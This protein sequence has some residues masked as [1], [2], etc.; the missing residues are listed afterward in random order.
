MFAQ[1]TRILAIA[2][3]TAFILGHAQ[4]AEQGEGEEVNLVGRQSASV[5][6]L[7]QEEQIPHAVVK[8]ADVAGLAGLPP[9]TDYYTIDPEVVAAAYSYFFHVEGDGHVFVVGSFI[10][11]AK[12]C[13]ELAVLEDIKKRN[14]GKEFASGLG[15][16]LKGIGTGLGNLVMHPGLSMKNAGEHF[17][18]TGRALERAVDSD[19]KVGR[20]ATGTDR[21]HLGGGPAGADRRRLAYELGVDVYTSNPVLQEAL[22]EY[23]R[24]RAAGGF[25]TWAIPY[26]IGMLSVMNPVGDD[27]NTE[28]L[29]RD[30]E[31]NELRRKIGEELEPVLGMD[32]E[33]GRAPLNN[34]LMNPNYTPRSIAYIGLDL[35]YLARV[36]N[37][38]MIVE[39]LAGAESPDEADVLALELRLYSFFHRRIEPLREFIPFQTLFAAK[40]ANDVFY[41]MFFGDTLRPWDHTRQGFDMMVDEAIASKARGMEIW[42]IGDVHPSLVQRAADRGVKIKQNILHDQQF[43]PMREQRQ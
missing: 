26:D 8:Y 25:A 3:L 13:H 34:L 24:L 22:I 10:N 17:R 4:G 19:A 9:R 1:A 21:S 43:F 38:P 36:G 15:D 2:C 12:L 5:P 7:P 27:A 33:D 28:V 14:K 31:P 32:R 42:T 40:G 35:S 6:W 41:F 37:L 30:Y 11:L 29:I 23:S 39:K 16:S 20:D 18:Q